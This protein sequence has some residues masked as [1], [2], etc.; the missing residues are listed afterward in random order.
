MGP[1]H[2]LLGCVCAVPCAAVLTHTVEQATASTAPRS[3]YGPQVS[4]RKATA[5]VSRLLQHI[6]G[7]V[8]FVLAWCEVD[9]SSS[10]T[11][12]SDFTE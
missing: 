3:E 6:P 4:T 10:G 9:A 5:P 7:H 11:E 2:G 1:S 8:L 12:N